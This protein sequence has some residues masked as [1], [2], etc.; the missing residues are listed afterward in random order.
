MHCATF[1][2]SLN[3]RQLSESMEKILKQLA[4]LS[5]FIPRSE[6]ENLTISNANIGWQIDH[7]LRVAN[8]VIAALVRSNPEEYKPSF[9]W[10]KHFVFFTQRI[11]R[12][13]VNA[14]AG[15][16]PTEE[17]TKSS[18]NLSVEQAR[19][20]VQLLEQMPPNHFF[21]HPFFGQVNVRETKVFIQ[22]HT[23]HHLKIIRDICI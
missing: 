4:E 1:C 12:G 16:L 6:E 19:A 8:Q 22:I 11:P 7:S 5:T 17:I 9:N 15:I 18:L 13:K 20:N 14:P 23:E 21:T 10:R 3:L 2:K